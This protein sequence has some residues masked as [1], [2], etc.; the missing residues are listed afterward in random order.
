MATTTKT[1]GN[2]TRNATLTLAALAACAA[3]FCGGCSTTGSSYNAV[4]TNPTPELLTLDQRPIDY[5]TMV[6]VSWNSNN[7]TIPSDIARAIYIDRPS[8]LTPYPVPH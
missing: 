1:I 3:A 2:S 6:A 4:S 8:R 5:R 7:R